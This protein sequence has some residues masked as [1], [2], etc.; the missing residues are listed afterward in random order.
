MVVSC[1]VAGAP[2]SQVLDLLDRF[3]GR[4]DSEFVPAKSTHPVVDVGAARDA[5][6]DVHQDLIADEVAVLVVDRFEA[7]EI[8]V[9]ERNHLGVAEV[10]H[11]VGQLDQRNAADPQTGEVV[12]LGSEP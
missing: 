7:V 11:P 2:I 10:S 4:D 12:T 1:I 8:A 9:Q 3:A 6:R 5:G